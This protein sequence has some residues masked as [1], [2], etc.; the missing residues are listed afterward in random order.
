VPVRGKQPRRPVSPTREF[1]LRITSE[2][3][4]WS[5]GYESFMVDAGLLSLSVIIILRLSTLERG[6]D[7][8]ACPRHSIL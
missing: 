2:S 5:I 1:I 3:T 6:A 7:L 8:A 4:E